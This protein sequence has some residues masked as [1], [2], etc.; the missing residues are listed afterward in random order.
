MTFHVSGPLLVT[1]DIVLA[2]LAISLLLAFIRLLRGPSL[3]DRVIA[4]DLLST[5]AVGIIVVYA[6]A[7]GEPVILDVAIVL[8]LVTFLGTIAFAYYVGKG[9]AP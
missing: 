6:I 3:P 5:L 1:V 2:M 9:G 8:A 4:L 7:T